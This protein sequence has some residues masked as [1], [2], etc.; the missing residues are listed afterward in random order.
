MKGLEFSYQSNA[1]AIAVLN[2]APVRLRLDGV[3]WSIVKAGPSTILL[4][5]GNHTVTLAVD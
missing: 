4:P 1:R 2:R 5:R 3:E